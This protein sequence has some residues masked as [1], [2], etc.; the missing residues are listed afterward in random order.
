MD[1]PD[2]NQPET[3]PYRIVL[4]EWISCAPFERL[5]GMDI[6]EAKDGRAILSMPFRYEFAQGAGL[7]H[8]GVLVSL[9]DTA[10]VMAIKSM[11]PEN[12]HFATIRLESE[13][14]H[15]V[16]QGIVTAKATAKR[17]GDRT[18]DG[19]ATVVDDAGRAVLSFRSTF[20]IARESQIR[21]NSE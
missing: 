9:A 20:K 7:M 4:P 15:P 11:V 12:T 14:L 8:G 16:R 1:Q 3:G 17:D 5:L 19:E 18:I 10:V 2:K 21:G 6:V 13:F